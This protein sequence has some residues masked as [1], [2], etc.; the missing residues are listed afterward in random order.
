MRNIEKI[1]SFLKIT[2]TENETKRRN[3]QNFD[4]EKSFKEENYEIIFLIFI[5]ENCS[6][7]FFLEL[8]KPNLQY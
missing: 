8:I 1:I 2:E 7:F 4:L 3:L 5:W 6:L